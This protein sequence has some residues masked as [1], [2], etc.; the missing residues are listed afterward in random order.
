MNARPIITAPPRSSL[1]I[2]GTWFGLAL[3]IL[4][5]FQSITGAAVIT[6]AVNSGLGGTSQSAFDANISA[7]DLVNLGQLTLS[8]VSST[9]AT[10][11]P[12]TLSGLHDGSAATSANLAFWYT[13]PTT[14]TFTLN[15]LA[16]PLGYE[17]SSVRNIQGFASHAGLYANQSFDILYS[18]VSAPL[19]FLP[20][21]TI[22]YQPFAANDV[23]SGSTM[24]TLTNTTG[25]LATSVAALQLNIPTPNG[26]TG[27]YREFDV[28]GAAIPEPSLFALLGLGGLLLRRGK[29]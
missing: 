7:T 17:I 15:T 1:K 22:S 21:A 28:F 13:N 12:Y 10:L 6:N 14:V 16:N 9:A 23:N 26:Q 3:V 8:G 18:T 4:L 2:A 11:P 19:T 25:V 20:L 5:G 29:K 27:V 24:V